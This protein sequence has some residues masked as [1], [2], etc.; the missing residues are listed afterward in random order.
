MPSGFPGKGKAASCSKPTGSRRSVRKKKLLVQNSSPSWHDSSSSS[1]A[2]AGGGGISGGDSD[3]GGGWKRTSS[4]LG[5]AASRPATA[6][7]GRRVDR[8]GV[9]IRT[10][11]RRRRPIPA[12]SG[13]RNSSQ[14][15]D[16]DSS[17]VGSEDP[18]DS[19]ESDEEEHEVDIVQHKPAAKAKAKAEA[20]G[21]ATGRRRPAAVTK[22]ISAK[23]GVRSRSQQDDSDSSYVD[24]EDGNVSTG[25]EKGEQGVGIVQRKPPA[26]AKAGAARRRRPTAA[27]KRGSTKSGSRRNSRQHDSDSS[28]VGKED[29]N[30]SEGSEEEVVQHKSAAKVQSKAKVGVG[31]RHRPTAVSKSGSAKPS[32]RRNFDSGSSYVGS[33]DAD[34]SAGSEEGEAVQRKPVAKAKAKAKG[35]AAGRRRPIA[36]SNSGSAKAGVRRKSQQH[37]SDSSH[38]ESENANGSSGSEE[39]EHEIEFMEHPPPA[40]AKGRAA[41]SASSSRRRSITDDADCATPRAVCNGPRNRL[42][43]STETAPARHLEMDSSGDEE[44]Q[45]LPAAAKNTKE[46]A[47]PGGSATR[48]G[49]GGSGGLNPKLIAL[50]DGD[51]DCLQN[52]DSDDATASD[53]S[54]DGGSGSA[55]TGGGG[56]SSG[57]KSKPIALSS[58]DDDCLRNTDSDN[59]AGS[60]GGDGQDDSSSDGEEPVLCRCGARDWQDGARWIRCDARGCRTWEHMRCSY[61]EKDNEGGKKSPPEF[62]LCLGCKPKGSSLATAKKKKGRRRSLTRCGGDE[63]AASSPKSLSSELPSPSGSPMS[64]D[65]R[66]GG[67]AGVD[68]GA[69]KS[70]VRRSRRVSGREKRRVVLRKNVVG[71]EEGYS[72]CSD[73]DMGMWG[74]GDGH[75]GA[76][77]GC[78]GNDSSNAYSDAESDGFWAPE[79]KVEMSQEYRCRCGGTLQNQDASSAG[80]GG[81]GGRASGSWV[82]CHN[83]ACGV[84]EHAAC[85]DF[86][87]SSTSSAPRTCVGRHWCRVCD[88]KGTKHARWEEKRRKKSKHAVIGAAAPGASPRPAHV[89][90]LAAESRRGRGKNKAMG[91]WHRSLLG[92]L[93]GA[94]LSGNTSLLNQVFHKVDDGDEDSGICI[95]RLLGAGQPSCLDVVS[96]LAGGSGGGETIVGG[97]N[98]LPVPDGQYFPPG[99]SLLMLAAGYWKNVV[100][101]STT[102]GASSAAACSAANSRSLET[103][104]ISDGSANPATGTSE[105]LCVDDIPEEPAAAG[106]A[107]AT[108]TAV[109]AAASKNMEKEQQA[110]TPAQNEASPPE[111][112]SIDVPGA[113]AQVL[114]SKTSTGTLPA[115]GSEAR[116]EVLRLV[117]KRSGA[118]AVL[119]V[120]EEGRTAVHHAAAVNGAG[121]VALLL[122]GELGEKAALV[123]VREA[124]RKSSQ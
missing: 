88:P 114:A 92:D 94:V 24:S 56:D 19:A 3:D 1:G 39:E 85:C 99:L 66:V 80:G 83:D 69:G 86:C 70:T 58:D 12:K 46:P 14:L 17:Y 54:G 78:G 10:R 71:D 36:S 68:D 6:R 25:S 105:L 113:P 112:A 74:G 35:G 110:E 2:G 37:D 15:V 53:G 43:K 96:F 7:S 119:A 42:K 109:A 55:R 102:V 52:T 64:Y 107:G 65:D 118:R 26:K 28:Y 90:A 45:F 32:A 21:G 63:W 111:L 122:G 108:T 87:L 103:E 11:E 13:I 82:Q 16:S 79:G 59:A 123:M 95:E 120:D 9:G 22:N 50:S 115:L 31:G 72:S 47:G 124:P 76:T 67:R 116:L 77:G 41:S 4:A 38:V 29:A 121:E 20:E 60:G 81:E 106:A 97:G 33:E 57:L 34:E 40:K 98:K 91:K 27:T 75:G 8:T 44:H 18:N 48:G 104:P 84:W 93:W 51:D 30:D 62:H 5:A 49:G 61:P 117:L 100:D 73:N 89:G 23:S 101:E